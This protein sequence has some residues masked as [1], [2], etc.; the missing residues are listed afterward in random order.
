MKKI[1]QWLS[2][3][4][5]TAIL[6][7]TANASWQVYQ[8][9]IPCKRPLTYRVA[10]VDPRFNLDEKTVAQLAVSAAAAWDTASGR[11]LFQLDQTNGKVA[12]SLVYDQRQAEAEVRRAERAKID[13]AATTLEELESQYKASKSKYSKTLAS[14]QQTVAY[15]NARGGAPA[16]EFK[17]VEAERQALNRQA[18]DVN[19]LAKDITAK[20]RSANKTVDAYNQDVGK[21]F[22]E[23]QFETGQRQITVFQFDDQAELK[24]VLAHE[25]GHA[26]GLGHVE[27]GN[28]LMSPVHAEGEAGNLQITSADMLALNQLC[29]AR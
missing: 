25:L 4:L 5:A 16:E 20:A 19:Q 13:A 3:C 7:V 1:I 29:N 26:L 14:Y 22:E 2:V 17:K 28:A 15:W 27:S 18:D 21:V 8:N 23:G 24:M 6:V 11:N 9:N 10:A 12:I